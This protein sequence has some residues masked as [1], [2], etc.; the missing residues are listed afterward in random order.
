LKRTKQLE[1][2]QVVDG[3]TKNHD[4][5]WPASYDECKR[6]VADIV[7]K[8][9][10]PDKLQLRPEKE[11]FEIFSADFMLDTNGKLWIIEFNFSPVLYDP[12]F[13]SEKNLTTAGL[14]RYHERVLATIHRQI[15]TLHASF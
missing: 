9:I 2:G 1:Y 4:S 10:Q 3:W 6:T 15:V 11:Q 13:A 14:K 5:V 12:S 7:N 8:E